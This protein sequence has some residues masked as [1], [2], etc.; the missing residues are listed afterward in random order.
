MQTYISWLERVKSP[1]CKSCL[2]KKS[3]YS[4]TNWARITQNYFDSSSSTTQNYNVHCQGLTL[5]NY[6]ERLTHLHVFIMVT[7]KAFWRTMMSWYDHI[8]SG[9]LTSHF[10]QQIVLSEFDCSLKCL[11]RQ[12]R[13]LEIHIRNMFY[14]KEYLFSSKIQQS[15]PNCWKWCT[16]AQKQ[17]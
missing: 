10:V 7:I 15:S 13:F 14:Y 6:V 8:Y 3:H 9:F 11:R 17:I 1:L 16:Q 4:S 5:S 12:M 2:S